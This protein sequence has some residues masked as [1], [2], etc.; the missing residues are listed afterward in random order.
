VALFKAL[1]PDLESSA[2]GWPPNQTYGAFLTY[3]AFHVAYQT[4]QMYSVRHLLGE[5]TPDN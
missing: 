4:G 3:A 1:N 2:P 5:E